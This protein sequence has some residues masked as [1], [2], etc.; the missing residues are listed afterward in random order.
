MRA[1]VELAD[2]DVGGGDG[3]SGIAVGVGVGVGVSRR[4]AARG[5][6]AGGRSAG[7]AG[8]TWTRS[9]GVAWGGAERARGLLQFEGQGR[10][11]ERG[12]G[13]ACSGR[14]GNDA[15]WVSV[16]SSRRFAS[17]PKRWRV[18]RRVA[19]HIR[20]CSTAH[21][22]VA[23]YFLASQP[24]EGPKP[25]AM[26]DGV[27]GGAGWR[28]NGDENGW[29]GRG[30]ACGK[31]WS[32]CRG[33]VC[34]CGRGSARM[35]GRLSERVAGGGSSDGRNGGEEGSSR[36]HTDRGCLAGGGRDGLTDRRRR[37]GVVGLATDWPEGTATVAVV[38]LPAWATPGAFRG[39]R[40]QRAV[41]RGWQ[42]GQ[43]GDDV[44]LRFPVAWSCAPE[45]FDVVEWAL[46]RLVAIKAAA[47]G[48]GL[49]ELTNVGIRLR[50]NRGEDGEGA[51][52]V[53]GG[54]GEDEGGCCRC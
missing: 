50:S 19:P 31:R 47:P 38:F 13:G 34:G 23:A 27:A 32:I 16:G 29:L 10:T 28:G 17:G 52:G 45:E 15:M 25:A 3:E 12:R 6:G 14:E 7:A 22:A 11:R 26:T 39:K 5:R 48:P 2:V 37:T 35:G 24:A 44:R 46:G 21:R 18:R 30:C 9:G 43:C 33:T 42:R 54:K 20:D 4:R 41:N 51:S 36:R 1:G 8:T 53:V 40:G 49:F